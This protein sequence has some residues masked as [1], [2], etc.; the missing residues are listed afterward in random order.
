MN[1]NRMKHF[2]LHDKKH[3]YSI[4][5]Y[6]IKLLKLSIK[7]LWQNS[8]QKHMTAKLIHYLLH[9]NNDFSGSRYSNYFSNYTLKVWKRCLWT[10][11]SHEQVYMFTKVWETPNYRRKTKKESEQAKVKEQRVL[12]RKTNKDSDYTLTSLTLGACFPITL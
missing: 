4:Q 7:S 11:S 2:E 8:S 9:V 12:L 5:N 3:G 1:Y 6:W 10:V